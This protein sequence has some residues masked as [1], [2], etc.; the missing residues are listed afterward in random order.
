MNRGRFIVSTGGGK[1]LIEYYALRHGFFTLGHSLQVIVAPTI[2]LLRQHDETFACYGMFHVDDVARIHFRTGDEARLD[3][4]A[5]YFQTTNP[6]ELFEALKHCEKHK[7]LIFVTYASVKKLFAILSNSDRKVD[8]CMWDEFHHLCQ[9]IEEQKRWLQTLWSDRNLFFSASEKR[10]RIVSTIDEELFGPKLADIG[11]ARLR[12]DGIVVPNIVIKPIRM[13][14]EGKRAKAL[15]REMKKTAER[16][17]FDLKDATLEAAGC[18]VAVRDMLETVGTANVVTFSQQVAIAKAII[19]SQAV[20]DELPDV[21][22]QTVHAGVPGRE[23]KEVYARVRTSVASLLGQHSI[24]KEGIDITCFNALVMARNMEVIGVQQAIGRIVRADPRDTEALKAGRISL[25]SPEGWHK[26][27]AT[28]YVLVRDESADDFRLWLRGFIE[29][30]TLSG[31][32]PAD[33]QFAD[34]T[35][36]RHGKKSM[37]TEW[38]L[39]LLAKAELESENLKG[40]VKNLI[41]E[42]DDVEAHEQDMNRCSKMSNLELLEA[43]CAVV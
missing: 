12:A 8:A 39:P 13:N 33:Y 1:T 2:D 14:E 42:I 4:N 25:D 16:N 22:L 34:I 9:Q 37:N 30:M 20:K 28:V 29:K 26:Y 38:V 40:I 23:R 3:A 10:G 36:E 18:I 21:L 32:S 41:V 35:E 43:A 27:T 6:G 17:G 24:V 5:P 31:F 15:S 11:Y 7:V 19:S